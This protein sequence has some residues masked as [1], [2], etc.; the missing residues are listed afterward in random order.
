MLRRQVPAALFLSF[1]CLLGAG[2]TGGIGHPQGDTGS[3]GNGGPGPSDPGII[4]VTGTG[5]RITIPTGT[6]GSGQVTCSPGTLAST[7]RVFRLTHTQY[8]NSVRAL[9]G[10]DVH[11]AA[12]FPADQNQAGFDRGMD[13]VVGDALGKSYRAAAESVAAQ[14]ASTSSAFTKVV[15]CDAAGG[16][17]CARSFIASFGRKAYR[18][19]LTDAEKSS[20]FTLF[21]NAANVVDGTADNFH[22]GVQ[23]VVETMLQNPKFLYRVELSNTTVDGFVQLSGVELAS[24]LSY[25][26]VNGPPDDTLLDMAESGQLTNADAVATQARRLIGLDAA[27]ETVRDF[28]HQWLV[29]DAYANKLT[30]SSKYPT[31]TPDLAPVLEQETEQFVREVTF[32]QG[33]GFASLMTAPFTYVNKTTAPLYGVTGSFGDSLTRVSL[34]ATKRAGLFTQLGFLAVKAY[35]NQS[36]PIH[37]GAFIQRSVLC[38]AIPDPPPNVPQLPALM[39]T[40]TTRQAVDAHTAADECKGCHHDYINPVGFGFENYDEAGVW[41]ATENNVTIDATGTLAGTSDP[42]AFTDAVGESAALAASPDARSCY[43]T[44]W[45]RYAFGRVTNAGDSCAVAAI[46]NNLGDDSYKITDLMV[47]ITRTRAFLFRAGGN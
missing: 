47:D 22:K 10:L 7:T 18:R 21:G 24:R 31:V 38:T 17:T 34:D 13:L 35:S 20:Y 9:T 42:I 25:F 44:T 19:A 4:D 32:T 16:D 37:R 26:L 45:L 6:G 12:E 29:M 30:K 46:A 11:P 2:C 27:K 40:Q 36:S 43:A 3:A 1:G 14:V 15:G 28:H 41:R 23:L 5:G 33:K 8:D 39:A